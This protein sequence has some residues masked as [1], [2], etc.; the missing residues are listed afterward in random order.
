MEFERMK[1]AVCA[2]VDAHAGEYTAASDAIWDHPEVNFHED[3]AAARLRG[4]LEENGFSI[5]DG[6][7]GMPNCFRAEYGEG[8]PVIAFLCEYDALSAMSQ[9]AG[10]AVR[11]PLTP[12]APGHGCG[13]NLLGVGSLGAAIA[14]KELIAAGALRGTV[15]CFGC[16]AE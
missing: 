1:S 11:E 13:H 16:P 12:G 8:R 4:L 14:I 2:S 9:R 10:C 5:T 6:L 7:D 15:V 3:T